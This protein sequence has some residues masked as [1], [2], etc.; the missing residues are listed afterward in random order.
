MRR[1]PVERYVE[2]IRAG[3]RVVLGR[4]ITLVESELAADQDLAAQ[5]LERIV[6]ATGAAVRLGI[7][8]VPGAGKSTFIEALGT[9][10][11]RRGEKV[12]VLAVDPTSP[13]SGGSILG[14]KTRMA[15]LSV[16]ANAFI[17]PSASGRSLGG[18][19]RKTR[20]AILLCE[21]AGYGNVLVETVGVGQ[22]ET[23]VAGMVDC[24]LLLMLARAGDELQGIKRGIIEMAD[25]VA[26][27]KADGDNRLPAEVARAQYE[28]AL[29]LFPVVAGGWRTRVVTCSAAE[30]HGVDAIWRLVEEHRAA[31]Q[32]SG[33]FAARRKRQQ[34]RALHDAVASALLDGFFSDAAVSKRMREIETE[35]EEGR[36][37]V[38]AAA[39]ELLRARERTT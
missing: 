11:T 37:S 26:I 25:I 19:A 2:G 14:D 35:V 22:S 31:M 7:T 24:F 10:L 15:K 30:G 8:G 28:S 1:L 36:A 5:V 34:R 20:E 18:V 29:Q 21:A 12:A 17:R 39:R 13:V 33:E 38:H 4:A 32:S 27:N 9:M 23:A 6:P 3:D 16:D